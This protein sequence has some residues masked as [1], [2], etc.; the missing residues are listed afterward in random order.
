MFIEFHVYVSKSGYNSPRITQVVLEED[1]N[2][3]KKLSKIV[4]FTRPFTASLSIYGTWVMGVDQS[5]K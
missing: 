4:W 3:A 1:P 2:N 5:F